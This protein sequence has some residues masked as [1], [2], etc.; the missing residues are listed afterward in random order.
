MKPK[1]G[2]M[3]GSR[4]WTVGQVLIEH[5]CRHAECALVDTR[6]NYLT[7]LHLNSVI[8]FIKA[9]LI[10]LEC[11]LYPMAGNPSLSMPVMTE[12]LS[13]VISIRSKLVIVTTSNWR[14]TFRNSTANQPSYVDGH[15]NVYNLSTQFSCLLM[16]ISIHVHQLSIFCII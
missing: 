2:C 1:H 14:Y 3:S 15:A 13:W 6:V 5:T 7:S 10:I 4:E 12:A 16:S 11:R 8:T 9:R